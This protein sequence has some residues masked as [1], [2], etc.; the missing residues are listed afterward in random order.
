MPVPETHAVPVGVGLDDDDDDVELEVVP[1][2]RG[3][4]VHTSGLG[5]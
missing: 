2:G 3:T 5:V 4:S 1:D